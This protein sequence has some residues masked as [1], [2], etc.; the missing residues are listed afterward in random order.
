MH[1]CTTHLRLCLLGALPPLGDLGLEL[2]D[3][4]LALVHLRLH[5][6]KQPAEELVLRLVIPAEGTRMRFIPRRSA[7]HCHGTCAW[8][9]T[10]RS[11]SERSSMWSFVRSLRVGEVRELTSADPAR[12]MTPPKLLLS[13]AMS[14]AGHPGLGGCLPGV[15]GAPTGCVGGENRHCRCEPDA[16]ERWTCK[17][18]PRLPR[19]HVRRLSLLNPPQTLPR[20]CAGRA[21]A[22][23]RGA[24]KTGAIAARLVVPASIARISQVP[25]ET[26]RL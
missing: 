20:V 13:I 14:A 23:R 22:C 10:R 9:A 7:R 25:G 16:G 15:R 12:V 8:P 5:I 3:L 4:I 1:I 6:L 18:P 26:K 11:F 2:G 24:L 19:G 17:I 21:E